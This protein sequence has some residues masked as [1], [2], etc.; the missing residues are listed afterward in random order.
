MESMAQRCLPARWVLGHQRNFRLLAVFMAS[1]VLSAPGAVAERIENPKVSVRLTAPDALRSVESANH[2]L[3]AI[4][5]EKQGELRVEAVR[6]RIGA[7]LALAGV[8]EPYFRGKNVEY[9]LWAH[10]IVADAHQTFAAE[11]SRAKAPQA[12]QNE[13]WAAWEQQLDSTLGQMVRT[14]RA[15][16]RSCV[17][18]AQAAQFSAPISAACRERLEKSS[19]ASEWSS[20]ELAENPSLIARL[21]MDEMQG[22]QEF[23]GAE[24]KNQVRFKALLSLDELGRVEGVSLSPHPKKQAA[25]QECIAKSLWLWVFPGVANAELEIPILLKSIKE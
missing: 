8:A 5:L 10:W 15:H 24:N 9:R 11:L 12:A 6:Q 3:A 22:C 1:A 21:R 7:I 4:T 23:V 16:L 2:Q 14:A 25:L 20:K 17:S 19:T 18:L 13:A